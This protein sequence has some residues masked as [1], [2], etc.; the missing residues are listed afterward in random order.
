MSEI[1]PQSLNDFWS[2][3]INGETFIEFQN[4]CRKV[5]NLSI[6]DV[7]IIKEN[8]KM[9]IQRCIEPDSANLLKRTN[10]HIGDVQ[11][12]KTLTMAAAIALAHD[13][14]F[15]LTTLLTGTKTIL[16]AQNE[17]RI[18]S[19]LQWIDKDRDKF[20][21][22]KGDDSQLE[23]Q[24]KQL[25]RDLRSGSYKTMVVSII[26][27]ETKHIK[28]LTNK[29]QNL[30]LIDKNFG[31]MILDDEADQAS[32]NT[33]IRKKSESPTY[34][35]INDLINCHSK[36]T[37]FVQVTATANALFCI[38]SDDKLS[39]KYVSI[40]R[41]SDKYIG[42]HTYF[43]NL[44]TIKFYVN[45]INQEDIPEIDDG[46]KDPPKSLIESLDYFLVASAIARNRDLKAPFTYLCHPDSSTK[47]HKRY[48]KWIDKYFDELN[49]MLYTE[50]GESKVLEK[51]NFNNLINQI[52]EKIGF[53]DLSDW[54]QIQ[55]EL[56]R[57]I[58]KV[59]RISIINKDNKISEIKG[60]WEQSR[61][62]IIIGAMS[63]ERGFTV[64]GL[65]VTYLSRNPGTNADNIQQRA[66]FCGY[67]SKDHLNLSRLWLDEGN[68]NFYKAALVTE[69]SIR[70]G[71]KDFLCNEKPY[72]KG[73]F[74]I[75]IKK[76]FR[77]TR[78]NIHDVLNTDGIF[79][80]FFP[81]YAQYL[82]FNQRERNLELGNE[83]IKKYNFVSQSFKKW[84]CLA[85]EEMTIDD[86]K[87]LLNKYQTCE[88]D[89]NHLAMLNTSIQNNLTQFKGSDPILTCI[90]LSV[91]KGT[92]IL[93][94]A[95]YHSHPSEY[96][97]K[98][99]TNRRGERIPEYELP[100]IRNMDR[101][102]DPKKNLGPIKWLA[103]RDM[104]KKDMVTLHLNLVKFAIQNEDLY[105]DEFESDRKL[106]SYFLNNQSKTFTI[107]IKFPDLDN[108]RF[109]SQ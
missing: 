27:K 102:Y 1:I 31:S 66:R 15:L 11:S 71:L 99:P 106:K 78:S 63:I 43:R 34:K 80:W 49:E 51:I 58:E 14:N 100:I 33:M 4:Y 105:D 13:N 87:N 21:F 12:G 42:I 52:T 54:S 97:I 25:D 95:S 23:T 108:W 68:L 79:G 32:L 7:E 40:S 93:N 69:N 48:R 46:Q 9:I 70:H 8:A 38:P 18:E 67:K 6:S 47:E 35:L 98:Y 92:E 5:E 61:I 29:F 64:E 30:N 28:D 37:T 73:G 65:M 53:P 62:H 41:R 24:V 77:P 103:D 96:K 50:Y 20:Y 16:K 59:P 74:S 76:P 107:H 26:L 89:S 75:P 81:K 101:G 94:E 104:V 90:R 60:F 39:P 17:S 55:S 86:L 85:T 19:I 84:R 3:S 2:P 22:Y 82:S 72:L 91:I 109:F 88:A 36:Y 10:L 45:L 44:E 57:I 56:I 83:I